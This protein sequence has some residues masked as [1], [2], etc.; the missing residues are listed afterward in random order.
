MAKRKSPAALFEVIHTAAPPPLKFNK[1]RR[2][3]WFGHRSDSSAAQ[4]LRS[5]HPSMIADEPNRSGGMAT[6]SAYSPE[7]ALRARFAEAAA[8]A[9]AAHEVAVFSA[10]EPEGLEMEDGPG[11]TTRSAVAAA[12][13]RPLPPVSQSAEVREIC[14]GALRI[15]P[16]RQ[17]LTFRLRYTTAALAAFIGLVLLGLSFVVG[18]RIT[19]RNNDELAMTALR[20]GQADP[21]VMSVGR[22]DSAAGR[23]AGERGNSAGD[24]SAYSSAQGRESAPT[25]SGPAAAAGVGNA[26]RTIG[27][28]YL[29]VQSYPDRKSAQ[30]AAD[31]LTAGGVACTV[32]HGLRWAP[33][34][35]SVVTVAG[36]PPHSSEGDKLA[37][38]IR[39][40][41]AEQAKL[42]HRYRFEPQGYQWN[43]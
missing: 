26:Q 19:D 43:Q 27:L 5:L 7:A 22:P 1:P 17:E 35:F 12:P 39:K 34:W 21:G 23:S 8:D 32:E 16:D 3:W 2:S 6:A 9:D 41:A 25:P 38:S 13:L 20:T 11:C 37:E 24:G 18:K 30:D 36:Y 15:D 33:N 28:D 31:M 29:V 40:V 42:G 10:D 14:G 4:M